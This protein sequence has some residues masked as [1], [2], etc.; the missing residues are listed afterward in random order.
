M[1]VYELNH[2]YGQYCL[3]QLRHRPLSLENFRCF[4]DI[5]GTLLITEATRHLHLNDK[6]TNIFSIDNDLPLFIPI[7]RA[8]F[9]LLNIALKIFPNAPVGVLGAQRDEKT[10]QA[11]I[12]YKN[13][14]LFEDRHV[15]IF[16]PMLATGETLTQSI[17][18]VLAYHPRA[19]SIISFIASVPGIQTLNTFENICLYVGAI[20]AN[21]DAHKYIVPGLGDFG[22]RW[23]GTEHK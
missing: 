15:F 5:L 6:N 9:S 23:F 16:E 2:P 13:L 19:I 4:S 20:D 21:L 12:Y 11:N 22:D 17:K 3:T 1:Y 7:L 10:A 14:P 18:E 8:G